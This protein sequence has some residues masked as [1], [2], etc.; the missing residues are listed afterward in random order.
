MKH[1]SAT[2]KILEIRLEN[3]KLVPCLSI[4]GLSTAECLGILQLA[5]KLQLEAQE[6]PAFFHF[7]SDPYLKL[8]D[9]DYRAATCG[10]LI[11]CCLVE[12]DLSLICECTSYSQ[13]PWE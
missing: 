10:S 1:L 4:G 12:L 2:A 11:E 9:V 6:K 7:S 5:I 3:P 13:L 8:L